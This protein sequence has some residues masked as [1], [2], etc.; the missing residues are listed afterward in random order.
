[1]KDDK[2]VYNNTNV[3]DAHHWPSELVLQAKVIYPIGEEE[4]VNSGQMNAHFVEYFDSV[5]FA[6]RQRRIIALIN[7]H[8]GVQINYWLDL[9]NT[10]LAAEDYK[11]EN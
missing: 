3:D 11:Y 9:E 8:C 4:Q 6:G 2:N 7:N 10:S 5:C 1:M